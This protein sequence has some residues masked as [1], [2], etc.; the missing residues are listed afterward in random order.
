MLLRENEKDVR[1]E[2]DET[3]NSTQI[4][5]LKYNNPE[6]DSRIGFRYSK[7]KDSDNSKSDFPTDSESPSNK[8]TSGGFLKQTRLMTW[9]NYLVFS[10]N[11]RPTMF[12]LLTPVMIC[13][14]LLFLQS[15]VNNF[16]KG[17]ENKNPEE[18]PLKSINKCKYPE[19]CTT[20]GYGII[21]K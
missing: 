1:K 2:K 11:I 18:I 12:Q 17:L 9:K 10:R 7:Y 5:Q 4:L 19:D 14:L 21:V 13:F 8:N 3:H 6:G 20:I 15:L 16:T